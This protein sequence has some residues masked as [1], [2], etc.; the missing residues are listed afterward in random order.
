VFFLQIFVAQLVVVNG[1]KVTT[2]LTEV[3][4]F[5]EIAAVGLRFGFGLLAR[6]VVGHKVAKV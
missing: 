6:R 2:I 3:A 4:V 5:I 1:A